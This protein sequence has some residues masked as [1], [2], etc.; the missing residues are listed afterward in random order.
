ML[1]LHTVSLKPHR[2]KARRSVLLFLF[3][4]KNTEAQKR[5]GAQLA[6]SP[7]ASLLLYTHSEPR[8]HSFHHHTRLPFC[9]GYR[10]NKHPALEFAFQAACAF[11]STADLQT[12][13][14]ER[15]LVC[16][17]RQDSH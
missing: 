6:F 5:G 17:D 4:D 14:V 16:E 13:S 3:V 2:G 10:R 8:T 9:N 7:A 1:A 12:S 11:E 15:A